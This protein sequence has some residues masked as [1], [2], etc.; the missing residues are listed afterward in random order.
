MSQL[1]TVLRALMQEVGI[2]VTELARQTGVGQPVIHR[3]ASG[4]TDNPKVASLSPI[5][6][7]FN[8]NISQLIGDEPLPLDRFAGSHNPFYRQWSRLPLLNWHQATKWPETLIPTEVQSYISTEA[9][10]SRHAFAL[11]ME[12]TT[13][14]PRFPLGA[15]II[16]EP[17][18][19]AQNNDFIA[20]HVNDE[21]KIQVKQV[22]FDGAEIYLKPLNTDFETKKVTKFH[23]ILG[24]MVQTLIEYHEDRR[25]LQTETEN[26]YPEVPSTIKRKKND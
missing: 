21:E 4:E 23:R 18:I 20:I 3:M 24:V 1:S 14:Q 9:P 7:F 16:I 5:A 8:V 12:D 2:T 22:L 10:V 6:K 15:L 25:P 19:K 11:R 17:T 13:M 26:L